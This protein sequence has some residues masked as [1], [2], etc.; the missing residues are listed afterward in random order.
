MVSYRGLDYSTTVPSLH[1]SPIALTLSLTMNVITNDRNSIEKAI[2][3]SVT[4]LVAEANFKTFAGIRTEAP[5]AIVEDSRIPPHGHSEK[6][7][8]VR[9]VFQITLRIRRYLDHVTV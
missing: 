4:C 1:K 5:V 3:P 6:G 2:S 8:E 7:I 9:F